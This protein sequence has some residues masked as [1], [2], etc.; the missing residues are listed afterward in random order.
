MLFS[1]DI[2]LG[3]RPSMLYT[4]DIPLGVRPSWS[5][6]TRLQRNWQGMKQIYIYISL[7]GLQINRQ[8]NPSEIKL[9]RRASGE[10]TLPISSLEADCCA[11]QSVARG[12]FGTRSYGF[13]RQGFY[14]LR[15]IT[16]AGEIEGATCCQKEIKTR[17]NCYCAIKPWEMESVWAVLCLKACVGRQSCPAVGELGRWLL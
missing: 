9:T 3:V 16:G 4:S 1:S 7:T 14:T 10:R 6:I 13:Y 8:R 2:P 17:E 5:T 11:N 12:V 15:K